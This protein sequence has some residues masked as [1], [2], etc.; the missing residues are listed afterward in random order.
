MAVNVSLLT[1]CYDKIKNN[2]ALIIAVDFD[3]V[4]CEDKFPNIGEFDIELIDCI[5]HLMRL[6]NRIVLW[7]CRENVHK[8]DE[9]GNIAIEWNM[10][11]EVI[12]KLQ[13]HE[14]N[15]DNVNSN[16]VPSSWD[17]WHGERRKVSA[18]VYID[19]RNPS[20]N[21]E[22][23]LCFLKNLII[24]AEQAKLDREQECQDSIN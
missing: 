14:L 1:K 20:Y 18:D 15:F 8:H 3:G 6:N 21:R 24:S 12:E 10:L 17:E 16:I 23:T 22:E 11:N 19:D 5:K 7:T 9:N 4:L 13:T 2:R